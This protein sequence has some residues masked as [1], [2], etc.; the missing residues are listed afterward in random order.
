MT[1]R[2]PSAWVGADFESGELGK[3]KCVE[4]ALVRE[5]RVAADAPKLVVPD[6]RAR[7]RETSLRRGSRDSQQGVCHI[8][9]LPV[10]REEETL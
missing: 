2:L 6:R 1:D 4:L 3:G 8:L 7:G 9:G 5:A 10:A